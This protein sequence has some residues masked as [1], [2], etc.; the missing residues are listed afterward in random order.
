MTRGTAGLVPTWLLSRCAPVSDSVHDDLGLALKQA[1]LSNSLSETNRHI[2]IRR[3]L[4]EGSSGKGM[5]RLR[6]VWPSHTQ[7][8]AHIDWSD[9][10]VGDSYRWIKMTPNTPLLHAITATSPPRG[11]TVGAPI[12]P[13]PL[14]E[15]VLGELP[16]GDHDIEWTIELWEQHEQGARVV[17]PSPYLLCTLIYKTPIIVKDNVDKI[18]GAVPLREWRGPDGESQQFFISMDSRLAVDGS[19][20]TVCVLH[21]SPSFADIAGDA[22]LGLRCTLSC[23]NTIIMSGEQVYGPNCANQNAGVLLRGQ[24]PTIDTNCPQ[25][26]TLLLH[27]DS[28][29]AI[30]DPDAK[31]YLTGSVVVHGDQITWTGK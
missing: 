11:K 1:F 23:G 25:G 17:P 10:L 21:A 28:N 27:G 14:D 13:V 24:V 31:R 4:R 5:L 9:W 2:V 12:T 18:L 16:I 19:S 15:Y 7:I 6:E 26:W 3:I 29:I 22:T 30:R 8:T 20:E